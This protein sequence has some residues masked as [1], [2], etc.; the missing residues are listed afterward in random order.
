MK[1]RRILIIAAVVILA[2]LNL[3][4]WWPAA[5]KPASRQAKIAADVPLRVEDFTI[6]GLPSGK[7]GPALRDLFQPKR[8][9]AVKAV[10]PKQPPGP[11]PKTP[12]ELEREAAQAELAQFRCMGLVFRG[13]KAQALITAGSQSY[14][15]GAGEQVG[16]RFVVDKI[17]ADGVWLKDPNTGIGGAVRLTA[18]NP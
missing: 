9:V 16:K 11:P 6:Q 10:L 13:G 12:E 3:W 8:P 14:M 4:R 2:G 17:E 15:V 18:G 1:N 7:T 5:E